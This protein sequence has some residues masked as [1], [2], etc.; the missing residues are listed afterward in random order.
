MKSTNLPI[1]NLKNGG[2]EEASNIRIEWPGTTFPA[3]TRLACANRLLGE[4]PQ[5]AAHPN[6][7][8]DR[9]KLT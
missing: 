7:V 9:E 2:T 5:P 4:L 8:D 3:G 1:S 6:V